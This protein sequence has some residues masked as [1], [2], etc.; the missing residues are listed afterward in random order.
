MFQEPA[1]VSDHQERV[2]PFFGNFDECL[3]NDGGGEDVPPSGVCLDVK[4]YRCFLPDQ[5]DKGSCCGRSLKGSCCGSLKGLKG[6][7][8]LDGVG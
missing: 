3:D 4:L 6:D 7:Q 8:N 5:S 2:E 1:T